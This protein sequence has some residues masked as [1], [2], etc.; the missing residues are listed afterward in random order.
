MRPV[1]LSSFADEIN[2]YIDYKI[3]CGFKEHSYTYPLKVFDSFCNARN[4]KGIN[5]TEDDV[6]AWTA[7]RPGEAA[8]TLTARLSAS[9]GLLNFL[10]QNGYSTICQVEARVPT[11]TFI[12]HI[13]SEQE[14][15]RYFNAVDTFAFQFQGYD[16]SMRIQIP[17]LFRLLYCCGTR[18]GETLAIKKKDINLEQGHI[19]LQ[20]TKND[21]ERY[22]VLGADMRNLMVQYADRRFY[23]LNNDDYIFTSYTGTKLFRS[24]LYPMHREILHMA[25]IPYYGEHKGPRIHDWR[26]TF[27]VRCLKKLLDSGMNMYTALPIL[28]AFLG[29]KNIFSTEKYV[30][31]TFYNYPDI[32]AKCKN[33]YEKIYGKGYQK[34][35]E[36]F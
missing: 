14:I 7:Q 28:S 29:H 5:F 35:E 24:R 13:Y 10:I 21:I 23:L 20:E 12:P 19:R 33:L 25:S 11:N 3:S 4:I 36:S 15:F 2:K 1:Y 16:K 26:H 8:R 32:E 6:S 30:R 34:L 22:I 18:I 17:V 27:A 31:L 9:K